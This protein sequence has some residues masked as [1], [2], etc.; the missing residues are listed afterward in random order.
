MAIFNF[1]HIL[2]TDLNAAIL[3]DDCN[4]AFKV[5]IPNGSAEINTTGTTAYKI[6]CNIA[7]FK[8]RLSEGD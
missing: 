5:F 7:I 4:A 1:V 2:P 6:E 8:N 3:S